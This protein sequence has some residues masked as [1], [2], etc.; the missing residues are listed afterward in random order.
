MGL[1]EK[2]IFFHFRNLAVSKI[3]NISEI[4]SDIFINLDKLYFQIFL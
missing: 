1:K 2:Y 4:K 3:R